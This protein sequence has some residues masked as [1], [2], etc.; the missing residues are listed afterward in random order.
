MARLN[1]RQQAF[2]MAMIHFG[3][4]NQTEAA[5]QAGYTDT[6]GSTA[7]IKVLAHKLAHDERIQEAIREE[8]QKLLSAS[9]I[10]AVKTLVQIADD[11]SA[12]KKD[13]LKA[14][15]MIMNRTGL[16][17]KTEHNVNVT[18]VDLTGAEVT[19]RITNAAK[20]LGLDPSRLLGGPT[21]DAGFTEVVA[22]D[23]EDISDML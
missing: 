11:V 1:E 15:E 12:E 2:V 13:R 7:G 9:T 3:G 6:G 19:T 18:R 4:I 23:L 8:G 22:D 10:M 5:R 21:V 16:A 17:A 14:C 20:F